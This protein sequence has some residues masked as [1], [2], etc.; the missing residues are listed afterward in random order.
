M[1]FKCSPNSA[2]IGIKSVHHNHYEDR[3]FMIRCC[4][5]SNGGEYTIHPY[6]TDY[7]NSYDGEMDKTCPNND[8]LVG[9][10]SKHH[11]RYEDRRFRFYCGSIFKA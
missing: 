7:V 1:D 6:L 5:L 9:L 11:N 4:D 8:V 3:R 2:M 10:N